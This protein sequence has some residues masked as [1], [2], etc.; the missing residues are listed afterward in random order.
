MLFKIDS[1]L[2]YFIITSLFKEEAFLFFKQ[3][4]KSVFIGDIQ[5]CLPCYTLDSCS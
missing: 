3:D 1:Y 2:D 5:R 4:D